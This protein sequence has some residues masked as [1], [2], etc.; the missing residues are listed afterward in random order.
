MIFMSLYYLSCVNRKIFWTRMLCSHIKLMWN[1][2][3]F[4]LVWYTCNFS[5]FKSWVQVQARLHSKPLPY[6]FKIYS[7]NFLGIWHKKLTKIHISIWMIYILCIL[8]T[9]KLISESKFVFFWWPGSP[10]SLIA[11]ILHRTH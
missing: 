1:N 4:E 11:L 6:L 7:I 5:F 3:L 10:I 2:K 9:F 8:F